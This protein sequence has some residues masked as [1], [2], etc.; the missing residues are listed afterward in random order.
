MVAQRVGSLFRKQ[1]LY[2]ENLVPKKTP[3]PLRTPRRLLQLFAALLFTLSLPACARPPQPSSPATTSKPVS[4]SLHV[5]VRPPDRTIEPIPVG[6]PGALPVQSGG[7]MSIDVDL[8]Q[9]A[10]IYLIWINSEG[11]IL[12][13]YPW[14][15]ETLEV[16]DFSQPPPVR[17]AT[18][19]IFSPLLGRS[20]TFGDRA[21]T[22]TVIFLSR[23]TALPEN[24]ELAALLASPPTSKFGQPTDLIQAS[25]P[26]PAAAKNDSALAAFL[27][28]LSKHFD[29]LEAVQFAHED[30]KPDETTQNPR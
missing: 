18:K 3:D 13:L 23:R 21:G 20:W 26:N 14:N 16:K 1:S 28:P 19:R 7:A 11:Q 27:E 8:A 4:G 10:F 24:V 25:I 29:S 6:D 9:P 30:K 22:E 15:N 5:L 12:P 2:M 17:R